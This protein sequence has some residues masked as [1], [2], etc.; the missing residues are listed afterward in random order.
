MSS[1]KRFA[2]VDSSDLRLLLKNNHEDY[3]SMDENSLNNDFLSNE[4]INAMNICSSL[5]LQHDPN[6]GLYYENI[7][8][9]LL[10]LIT[11]FIMPH[12]LELWCLYATSR[13]Y[14]ET[15]ERLYSKQKYKNISFK[16][17]GW[18]SDL[19]D[20][21]E[22][23][24][25]LFYIKDIKSVISCRSK[26][27]SQCIKHG[28]WS[29]IKLFINNGWQFTLSHLCKAIKYGTMDN[30][31]YIGKV[32]Y[33]KKTT[34][35]THKPLRIASCIGDIEKIKWLSKRGYRAD[36]T[37]FYN[38]IC[39]GNED[40]IKWIMN[41]GKFTITDYHKHLTGAA[42]FGHL[43]LIKDAFGAD[44]PLNPRINEGL[45]S[46]LFDAAIHGGNMECIEFLWQYNPS[47]NRMHFNAA[48]NTRNR[49]VINWLMERNCPFSPTTFDF[50]ILNQDNTTAQWLYS[51]ECSPSF[52]AF[53]YAVKLGDEKAMRWL[54]EIGCPWNAA[55]F[56]DVLAHKNKNLLDW[57]INEKCPYNSDVLE[58]ALYYENYECID[59]LVKSGVKL[60]PLC[61]M[62]SILRYDLKFI[63]SLFNDDFF[64]NPDY[65]YERHTYIEAAVQ[66]NKYEI[67]EWLYYKNIRI[68]KAA[69]KI[70]LEK[71]NHSMINKLDSLSPNRN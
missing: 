44:N 24:H 22:G 71:N 11:G 50:C 27:I 10:E 57:F 29:M 51:K 6:S 65:C 31:K 26:L 68:N 39:H 20:I 70:A 45:L 35:P 14:R 56:A 41:K 46:K 52:N 61:L 2:P 28:N 67:V 49:N 53:R 55:C 15:I 60:T 54:K 1:K 40:N 5:S 66:E 3:L 18:R 30:L 17:I 7:P 25:P 43:N 23:P 19:L 33:I 42:Q 32:G 38:I 34:K 47:L 8:F 13:Y 4:K 9:E 16:H 36:E 69:Y 48:V 64:A 37:T 12:S 59:Y 58:S 21:V 62:I 63:S